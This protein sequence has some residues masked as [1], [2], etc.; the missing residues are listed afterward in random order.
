[1]NVSI[2]TVFP[3]L[4][5]PFLSVSLIKR[6]QEKGLIGID[7]QSFF[8]LVPPKKRIDAATFGPG[9]GMLIRPEV[10]QDAVERQEKAHGKAFKIFFSPQGE[11][12]NQRLLAKI[13]V[14][15]QHAGH[16]MLFPARYEG[17]DA[18]VEQEYA[19]MI[20]SV[21]DFVL[22]GGDIP[23]MMLLEGFLRLI[24]GIVGKEESVHEES[25]T[26]PFTDYPE[27]TEPVEWKNRLVPDIVRSGNHAAIA[28][29]RMHQAARTS[30]RKHFSW[31]RSHA[32]TKKQQDC[33]ASYMPRH[34]VALVH[35][36]VL[37]GGERGVGTTSVTSIDLHDIARSC[38]TYGV[39]EFFVV[40]PLL[41]QKRIVKKLLD[42]W[43][44][45]NGIMYNKSRHRAVK[46]VTVQDTIE[47]TIAAIE[48]QEGV[49]PLVIATSAVTGLVHAPLIT[50]YDQVT[51]WQLDRPVL[52]VFG[53]GQGLRPEFLC[54]CDFQL[55]PIE[56]FSDF[57]HLSVRS[58]VAVV[59][60]R[61]LG[62]NSKDGGNQG[63]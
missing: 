50:F 10:V 62:I 33:A 34:Y 38:A 32:M 22:M 30:V 54:Q 8:S 44:S 56:G 26:G 16:V 5:E 36:D 9:S 13:A 48:Q 3:E 1:M 49:A 11:P 53:T 24:P 51:A 37:I 23:A 46:L 60:D 45:D 28:D 63:E 57:N 61:W 21:G 41:D 20:V 27:Y 2:I 35:G 7:V 43:C 55:L 4:Y 52:L 18:R 19:D 29:W 15:A 47:Q 12:L 17:M 6:A 40:T 25:F 58:A 31:M 39:K 14:Q 59:L 42:F